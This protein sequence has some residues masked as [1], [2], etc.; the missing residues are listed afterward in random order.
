MYTS[1][2]T[3]KNDIKNN[4]RTYIMQHLITLNI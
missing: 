3:K 1:N 4:I 2:I